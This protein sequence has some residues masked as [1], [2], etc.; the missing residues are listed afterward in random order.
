VDPLVV[1][2]LDPGGEQ[3]VEF[4]Q[5]PNRGAGAVGVRGDLDQ[6]LVPHGAVEP[7]DLAP[8][9]GPPG[10]GVGQLDAQHGAGPAQPGVDEHGSV[11]DIE[12]RWAAAG[13]QAHPQR[14]PQCHRVL[15]VPPAGRDHRPGMVVQEGDQDRFASPDQRAVHR[16][17]DPAEVRGVGLE[18]P[19]RRR[20]RAV[21]ANTFNLGDAGA[22]EG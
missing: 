17:S 12:L 16:V 21:G 22:G 4:A 18:P 10:L 3:V 5:G 8:P 20:R 19:E 13:S 11:I 9:G 14:F 6:E 7:L 2:L 15:R 1:D